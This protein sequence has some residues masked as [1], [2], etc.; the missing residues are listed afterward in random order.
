MNFHTHK[1]KYTKHTQANV[2]YTPNTYT[3]KRQPHSAH[4]LRD[5]LP[6][7]PYTLFQA[8]P[9]Y[10]CEI[11]PARFLTTRAQRFDVEIIVSL[12]CVRRVVRMY[13]YLR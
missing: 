9:L 2:D 4:R 13:T 7:K 10:R 5:R 1:H 8:P 3:K 6:N 12:A 11:E